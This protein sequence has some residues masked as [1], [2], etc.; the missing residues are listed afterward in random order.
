MLLR[1]EGDEEDVSGGKM[2][3][4]RKRRSGVVGGGDDG[5]QSHTA[6][7]LVQKG[8]QTLKTKVQ[9]WEHRAPWQTPWP[10]VPPYLQLPS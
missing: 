9:D 7:C 10:A 4:G 1:E 5:V 2:K 8:C 6:G 3:G